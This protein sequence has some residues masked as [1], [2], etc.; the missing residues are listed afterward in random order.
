MRRCLFGVAGVLL[1]AGV[2]TADKSSSVPADPHVEGREPT[3][4][5]RQFHEPDPPRSGG[6]SIE[7]QQRRGEDQVREFVRWWFGR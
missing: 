4:L 7:W 5:A 1:A 3:P 2:A 6:V